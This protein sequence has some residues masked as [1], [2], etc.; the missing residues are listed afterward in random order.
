METQAFEK[1][2]VPPVVK[3]IAKQP[4]KPIAKLEAKPISPLDKIDEMLK[5]KYQKLKSLYT[6]VV[7]CDRSKERLDAKYQASMKAFAEQCFELWKLERGNQGSRKGKGFDTK[8]K[9]R[10]IDKGRAYRAMKKYCPEYLKLN[11]PKQNQLRSQGTKSNSVLQVALPM[12]ER[13]QDLFQKCVQRV[14]GLEKATFIML[15][16][17]VQ[18]AAKLLQAAPS[19]VADQTEEAQEAVAVND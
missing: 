6:I 10:K 8:L 14:G 5:P 18:E 1:S 16:A 2:A 7:N 15:N 13:E 3:A 12:A 11:P 9:N 19:T 4:A 17:L